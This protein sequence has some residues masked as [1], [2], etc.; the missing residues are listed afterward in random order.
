MLPSPANITFRERLDGVVIFFFMQAA[1]ITLE[2]SVRWSL[3]R[4]GSQVSSR[5]F[6][7]TLFGYVWVTA[8]LW[9]SLPHAGDVLLRIRFGEQPLFT[10]SP[11]EAWVKK[12]V[13]ALP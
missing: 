7:K 11:N 2:D 5:I 10:A 9:L 1:A 4:T 12:F 3:R 8:F 6:A 13:D